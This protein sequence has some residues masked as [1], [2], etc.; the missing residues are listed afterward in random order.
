MR[1]ADIG[2]TQ[3]TKRERFVANNWPCSELH[4]PFLLFVTTSQETRGAEADPFRGNKVFS[5][6]E[7][8]Q[9][10]S[11]TTGLFELQ[12]SELNT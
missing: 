7:E 1:G 11:V 10:L 5:C 8:D 4:T 9:L 3:T 6:R 2:I 12:Q